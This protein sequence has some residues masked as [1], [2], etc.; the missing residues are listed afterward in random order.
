MTTGKSLAQSGILS[1]VPDR[2]RNTWTRYV[3]STDIAELASTKI[4]DAYWAKLSFSAGLGSSTEI[5]YI[6]HKFST[7]ADL[8]TEYPDLLKPDLMAA[9]ETGKTSWL[10]Q[11]ISAAEYIIQDLREKGVIISPSQILDP[12]I[13]K[14]A[15]IHKTA[16]IIMQSFGE[17][18]K[19]AMGA[20]DGR[21]RNSLNIKAYCIDEKETARLD[22]RDKTRMSELQS[23]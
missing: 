12:S 11:T 1:W 5:Q 21:Y 9:F 13:F 20:A 6:G 18:Y 8:K 10:E 4:Y 14:R 17:D 15:S 7:D 16:S 23:R 22:D 2:D 19:E 3:R